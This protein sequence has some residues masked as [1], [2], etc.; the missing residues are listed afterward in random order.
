MGQRIG[1]LHHIGGGNLGDDATQ[2]AVMQNIR[3]RW[4]DTVLIGLSVNPDD[5]EKRHGI[6]S[7]AI[8][9]RRWSLGYVSGS[10]EETVK[11][12]LKRMVGRS[13]VLFCLLRAI[14]SVAIR[15]PKEVLQEIAFLVGSFRIVRSLDLLVINGGGQLTE[16]GGPWEFPYTI[17][18]WIA[19]ARVANVQRVFLNVGA[20]PL[21]QPLSKFFV[22]SALGL[23]DYESFR[24]EESKA[25]V[26]RIGFV[27]RSLVSRDSVYGLDTSIL[28]V[29]S[30]R[31]GPEHGTVGLAPMPYCD[32]RAFPEKDQAVYDAF[33]RR[34]G[35]FGSWLISHGYQVELFGS[36]IGIDPLAMTDLRAELKTEGDVFGGAQ[37]VRSLEELLARMSLMDYVVTCR[38]HGLVF[39]HLLNKPVLAISHHPKMTAL[40]NEI[41]LGRYCVDIRTLDLDVLTET[42]AAVV[43]NTDDIKERMAESLRCYRGELSRQFDQLFPLGVG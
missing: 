3:R 27:G 33:I 26:R 16:W 37:G 18:K 17:F 10:P 36:D 23:A 40:M 11:G 35:L 28:E 8:R 12:K 31:R 34:L 20:G 1:L 39:A 24:D 32:P 2:D 43:K 9:R 6:P 13:R 30:G 41:G 7:Y 5:T 15:M 38:F 25:L 21:T 22:R 42:F 4:P 14:H 29:S 19:L